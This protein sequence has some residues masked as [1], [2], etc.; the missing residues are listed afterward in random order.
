LAHIAQDRRNIGAWGGA[1]TMDMGTSLTGIWLL[2]MGAI[3]ILDAKLFAAAPPAGERKIGPLVWGII[4]LSVA[5][6]TALNGLWGLFNWI[7]SIEM[8]GFNPVTWILGFMGTS[9][10]LAL[11]VFL[12]LGGISRIR[13]L[14]PGKAVLKIVLGCCLAG[15]GLTAFVAQ[16]FVGYGY[17]Y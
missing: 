3:G 14:A 2:H 10:E 6:L 9:V 7:I 1:R 17:Y 5:G 16:F 13:R 8:I 4:V 15:L 11:C 12:I